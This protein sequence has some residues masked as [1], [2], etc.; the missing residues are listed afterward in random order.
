MRWFI[1]CLAVG[2]VSSQDDEVV[3]VRNGKDLIYEA[4][5]MRYVGIG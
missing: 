5:K 3:S 2:I 4:M 1:L